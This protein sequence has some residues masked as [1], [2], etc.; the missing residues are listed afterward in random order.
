MWRVRTLVLNPAA[1]TLCYF[2]YRCVFS[3]HSVLI[4]AVNHCY[5]D[6]CLLKA[7]FHSEVV[8]WSEETVLLAMN[9]TPGFRLLPFLCYK[10]KCSGRFWPHNYNKWSPLKRHLLHLFFFISTF[11][12]VFLIGFL[13]AFTPTQ[14]A[15]CVHVHSPGGDFTI[16]ILPTQKSAIK[17]LFFIQVF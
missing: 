1:F 6:F 16:S 12:K 13:N 17:Y 10:Q 8:D 4:I 2:L 11:Y 3:P 15:Y 7:R 9:L 5:N 14:I